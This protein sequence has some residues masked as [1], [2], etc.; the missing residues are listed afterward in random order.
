MSIKVTTCVWDTCLH[1]GTKLLMMLALADNAND[2]GVA[3]PSMATLAQR[4]RIGERAALTHIAALE[5]SGDIYVHR[6]PGLHNV[7]IVRSALTDE[8]QRRQAAAFLN[9]MFGVKDQKVEADD[10]L[11]PP[12][13]TNRG[14]PLIKRSGGG[15]PAITPDQTFTPDQTI[16]G[17]SAAP[18]IKRSGGGD[19]PIRRSKSVVVVQADDLPIEQQQ[20]RDPTPIERELFSAQ[21]IPEPVWRGWMTASAEQVVACL[22]H[23]TGEP[24]V[25]NPV[26]LARAMLEREQSAPAP[27]YVQAARRK[28]DDARPDRLKAWEDA[29]WDPRFVR[30]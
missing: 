13:Q 5:R 22:L 17:E 27:K 21:S 20:Q 26:G 6:R 9:S 16:T 30:T 29:G 7:Y 24:N 3:W 10:F 23:V 8:V 1:S 11:L 2:Y 18:L 14:T 12:D 19:H 25:T 28:L 4:A 15:D